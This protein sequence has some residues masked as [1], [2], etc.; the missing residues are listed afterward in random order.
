MRDA[1]DWAKLVRGWNKLVNVIVINRMLGTEYVLWSEIGCPPI[2][3]LPLQMELPMGD[4][5]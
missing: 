4:D 1:V 5:H 3:S 2:T